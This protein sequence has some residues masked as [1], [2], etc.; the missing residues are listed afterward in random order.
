MK[1]ETCAW[2]VE[3]DW[4]FENERYETSCGEA[5]VFETGT[6]KENGFTFCPYCGKRIEYGGEYA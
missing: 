4:L 6:P 5:F 1:I 3:A 2:R